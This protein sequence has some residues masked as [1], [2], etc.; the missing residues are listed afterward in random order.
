[1]DEIHKEINALSDK[2]QDDLKSELEALSG[3][4]GLQI[5]TTYPQVLEKY[6]HYK[7]KCLGMEYKVEEHCDQFTSFVNRKLTSFEN[8][9][10]AK[11]MTPQ[12]DPSCWDLNGI[13]TK[14]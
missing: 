8:R 9:I 13:Q 2:I 14:I 1:M 3:E 11:S 4:S 5:G 10:E 12:F 6:K 7:R